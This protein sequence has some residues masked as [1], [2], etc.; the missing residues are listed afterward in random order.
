[1]VGLPGREEEGSGTYENQSFFRPLASFP[2]PSDAARTWLP[3]GP[4]RDPSLPRL[5][6]LSAR[7]NLFTSVSRQRIDRPW[8]FF[9][10]FI[11][12]V[13]DFSFQEFNFAVVSALKSCGVDLAASFS[14]SESKNSRVAGSYS[15]WEASSA[16][17]KAT[18]EVPVAVQGTL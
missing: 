7:L 11:A 10:S 15:S 17:C 1:V 18:P 4:T 8:I 12:N 13:E 16:L 3:P 6:W 9:S 14:R 2:S 5:G